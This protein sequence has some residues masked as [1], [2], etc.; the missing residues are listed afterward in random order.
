[1][2]EKME[3]K[4]ILNNIKHFKNKNINEKI[5]EIIKMNDFSSPNIIN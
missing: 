3:E 5:N 2:E 1:M 4:K